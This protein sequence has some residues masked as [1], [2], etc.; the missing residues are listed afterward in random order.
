MVEQPE[1]VDQ[2]LVFYYCAHCL[3]T[4]ESGESIGGTI[5]DVYSHWQSAHIINLPFQFSVAQIAVCHFGDAV[6]TYRELMKHQQQAHAGERLAI[7]NYQDR[8]KCGICLKSVGESIVDHFDLE[9]KTIA[10]ADIFNPMRLSEQQLDEL[11]AIDIHKKRQCGHCEAIFETENEM[12][13]HHSIGHEHETKMSKPYNDNR[14]PFLICGYCQQKI[15]RTAYFSHIKM[16]PYVFKCWKCTYHTNDLVT[17]IIHDRQ[18]HERD[19][20]NYHCAMFADWVRSHFYKSRI[21]FP[22]GLAL[23]ASNVLGTKFDESKVFEMFLDGMVDVVK[24]KFA[25]LNQHDAS[26][27]EKMMITPKDSA[28]PPANTDTVD[29]VGEG[30]GAGDSTPCSI[31]PDD[32]AFLMQE[33]QKQNELANNLLIMQLPRMSNLEPA[34]VFLKICDE[35]D[36]N[37]QKDDIVQAIR[38]HDDIIVTLKDYDQK[39]DIRTAAGRRPIM[40]SML[41]KLSA[42]QWDKR[43]KV[44]SHTTRYYSEMLSMAREAK[45]FRIISFYELTK[46]GIVATRASTGDERT[47]I[48]K[49]EFDNYLMRCRRHKN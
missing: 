28:A 25:L 18:L 20:L 3:D 35:L 1:P 17:L 22:N 44:L 11:L 7:V 15:D 43:V 42:G 27:V 2:P 34:D 41:H 40:R 46:K 31:A 10:Q 32:S 21:V 33:L 39:E 23:K 48:S 19:T 26:V 16:H 38:R 6:G 24:S 49:A 47:F 37:V 45:K 30:N 5:N 12:S 13:I 8:T 29:G 14:N 4:N 9:H 36:V